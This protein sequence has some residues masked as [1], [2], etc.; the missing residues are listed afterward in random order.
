MIN[1]IRA[2]DLNADTFLTE[3]DGGKWFD[4]LK[5]TGKHCAQIRIRVQFS[6][7]P[8]LND[9]RFRSLFS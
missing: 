8:P 4:P 9:P 7:V 5:S 2:Q 3:K 1:E 6:D